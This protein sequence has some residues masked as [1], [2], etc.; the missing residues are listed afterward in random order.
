VVV[1]QLEEALGTTLLHRGSRGVSATAPGELLLRRAEELLGM[2]DD[3]VGEL[4]ELQDE[5]VG[6]FVIGCHDALGSYFL[7]AFLPSF[8]ERYPR[9]E[10][11]LWNR[12]SA[13][14][15]EAILAR[16]VHFG[17]VVNT[18]PHDDLVIRR[19]W[20]DRIEV[21]GPASSLDPMA[22]FRAGTL[23]YPNREPFLT[24]IGQLDAEG[25]APARRLT[26]G[27]LG[28]TRILARALGFGLLPRRVA[29]DGDLGLRSLGDQLPRHDDVIHLVSR[30]DLPRTKGTRVL[31][32]ALMV[33]AASM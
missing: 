31:R 1:N 4:N 30:A 18:V 20:T 19:A 2:V 27:D 22:D 10:L 17:L 21:F 13:E 24:L 29:M 3:V 11:T 5:E 32:D 25:I 15:R 8:V 26:C 12:S 6:S 7:P 23:V 33:Q 9:I 16:E 14:V 28:L